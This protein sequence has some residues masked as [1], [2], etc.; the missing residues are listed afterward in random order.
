[1]TFHGQ[2]LK[3]HLFCCYQY[4][5]KNTTPATAILPDMSAVN[6]RGNVIRIIGHL[7]DI[8]S[9]GIIGH[10]NMVDT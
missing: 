9:A 3:D 7:L 5:Y 10:L 2:F 8:G 4:Y 6:K 1:M